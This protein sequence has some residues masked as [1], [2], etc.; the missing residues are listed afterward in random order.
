MLPGCSWMLLLAPS[1]H[2]HTHIHTHTHECNALLWEVCSRRECSQLEPAGEHPSLGTSGHNGDWPSGTLTA[3]WE[4]NEDFNSNELVC[5]FLEKNLGL[6]DTQCNVV[7]LVGHLGCFHVLAVVDRAAVNIGVRV[8]FWIVVFS[9]YMPRG[10]TAGSYG[11]S[12]FGFLR[13]L[14]YIPTNSVGGFPFLRTLS[15]ICCL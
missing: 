13:N 3:N 7:Y 1:T 12:I 8:S 4:K 5:T 2:P 10:G 9:G 6:D 15:S 11:G 14:H